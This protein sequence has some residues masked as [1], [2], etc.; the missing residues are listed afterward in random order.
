MI[1]AYLFMFAP[2]RNSCLWN[3]SSIGRES[4]NGYGLLRRVAQTVEK[5]NKSE[6]VKRL[7]P[8]KMGKEVPY[9]FHTV[10][11][12]RKEPLNPM[13]DDKIHCLVVIYAFSHFIRMYPEK[14]V[15]ATHTTESMLLSQIFLGSLESLFIIEEPPSWVRVSLFSFWNMP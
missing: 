15:D 3:V 4:K 14:S 13:D 6:R 1:I 10:H 2:R 12:D 7:L 9:P 5:I 8:I 11:I